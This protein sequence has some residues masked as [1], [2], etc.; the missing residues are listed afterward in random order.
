MCLNMFKD[1]L[2]NCCVQTNNLNGNIYSYILVTSDINE[3]TIPTLACCRTIFVCACT[4]TYTWICNSTKWIL[5]FTSA[6]YIII[7]TSIKQGIIKCKIVNTYKHTR[8]QKLLLMFLL[9]MNI[10]HRGLNWPSSRSELLL[11]RGEYGPT[12]YLWEVSTVVCEM[13]MPKWN[14]VRTFYIHIYLYV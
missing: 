13:L 7:W 10:F 6:T 2:F 14:I 3:L 11:E 12:C 9:V 5:F 4:V 8:I 1:L